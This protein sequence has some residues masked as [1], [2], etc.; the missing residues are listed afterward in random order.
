MDD[1]SDYA[2]LAA[3]PEVIVK[4]GM[5]NNKVHAINRD[6]DDIPPF[7]ILCCHS[8]DMAFILAGYDDVIRQHCGEDDFVHFP[9]GYANQKLCTYAIMGVKYY[10][11]FGYIY[12]PDYKSLWCDNEQTE[13]AKKLNRYKYVNDHILQH[14]H[15]AN[16]F[17]KP[18][19]LLQLTESY[20]AL[21]K[22][23]YIR[24]KAANFFL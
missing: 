9:D 5:S 16:G 7:D 4:H 2:R 22:N 17:G 8:D 6:L 15:P 24:R 13:V 11:R 12:N 10:K 1:T 3:Y 23:T 14:R 20:N 21:D 19:A 18:D